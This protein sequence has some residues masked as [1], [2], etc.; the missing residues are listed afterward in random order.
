MFIDC[1]VGFTENVLCPSRV[2]CV[3]C[4]LHLLGSPRPH[5]IGSRNV[6]GVF[7]VRVY[8]MISILFTCEPLQGD[9]GCTWEVK[10]PFNDLVKVGQL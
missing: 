4:F 6:V 2:H 3:A 9:D 10:L 7:T 8:W 5:K 1:K